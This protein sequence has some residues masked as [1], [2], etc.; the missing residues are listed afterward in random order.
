MYNSINLS[1]LARADSRRR[2]CLQ[3]GQKESFWRYTLD[4]GGFG[5]RS[6]IAESENFPM[7]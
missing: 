4:S 1:G 6:G 2:Y 7:V 3:G 5:G